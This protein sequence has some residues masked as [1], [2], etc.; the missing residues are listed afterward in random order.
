MHSQ[1]TS[2]CALVAVLVVVLSLSSVSGLSSAFPSRFERRPCSLVEAAASKGVGGFREGGC[3]VQSKLGTAPPY[4]LTSSDGNRLLMHAGETNCTV[5]LTKCRTDLCYTIRDATV[6]DMPLS[7]SPTGGKP[8]FFERV[9]AV[10]GVRASDLRLREHGITFAPSETTVVLRYTT[11]LCGDFYLA[12]GGVSVQD[13]VQP[14]PAIMS[15]SSGMPTD[16]PC[17]D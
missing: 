5:T 14:I 15:V 10:A 1:Y 17:S 11:K 9:D 8:G 13:C 16:L 4:G 2:F 6:T 12:H 3:D 7:L